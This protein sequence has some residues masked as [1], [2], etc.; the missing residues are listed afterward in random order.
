MKSFPIASLALVLALSGCSSSPSLEDQRRLVEYDNCI[1]FEI[2]RANQMLQTSGKSTKIPFLA[3]QPESFD[4]SH[5][6]TNFVEYSE[7]ISRCESYRP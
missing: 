4:F 2:A 6:Y 7:I 3:G 1:K 5:R